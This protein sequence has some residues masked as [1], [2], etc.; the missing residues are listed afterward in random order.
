MLYRR[1]WHNIVKQLSERKKER[2]REREKG[3]KE[4]RKKER[5]NKAEPEVFKLPRKFMGIEAPNQI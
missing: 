5:I 2:K 1:Y 4:G 3:R